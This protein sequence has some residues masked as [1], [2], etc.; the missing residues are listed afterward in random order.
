MVYVG[1]LLSL[2]IPC[3]VCAGIVLL[4]FLWGPQFGAIIRQILA[5]I[6]GPS[7]TIGLGMAISIHSA[8]YD[9]QTYGVYFG[10]YLL[11]CLPTAIFLTKRLDRRF[12]SASDVFR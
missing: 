7:V 4:L 1:V 5:A 2:V 10:L 9:L 8:D 11:G 6:G 12:E 3:L